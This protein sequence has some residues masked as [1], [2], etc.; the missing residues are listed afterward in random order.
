MSGKYMH[1]PEKSI[2]NIYVRFWERCEEYIW[3]ECDKKIYAWDKLLL[4]L[5]PI[6][7][8]KSSI[9]QI[10]LLTVKMR[11]R[12][13]F[14]FLPAVILGGLWGFLISWHR[15]YTMIIRGMVRFV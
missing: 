10:L 14:M 7:N 4:L 15:L 3:L 13:D 5:W 12:L 6:L 8:H 11:A 1:V 2:A 9:P